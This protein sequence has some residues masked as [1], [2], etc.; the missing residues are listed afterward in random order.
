MFMQ[1]AQ[2]QDQLKRDQELAEE[3]QKKYEEVRT[4]FVFCSHIKDLK[5]MND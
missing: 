2:L 4:C 1:L 5:I 3:S